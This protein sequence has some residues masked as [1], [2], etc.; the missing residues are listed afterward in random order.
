MEEYL[1]YVGTI[2]GILAAFAIS[3]HAN[4]NATI[5]KAEARA[6]KAR[7]DYVQLLENRIKALE[8]SLQD[9]FNERKII[10]EERDYLRTENF[11]LGRK[12]SELETI[13]RKA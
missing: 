12:V 3:L 5:A 1:P 11:R 13:I 4:R 6:D 7:S 10:T 9:C 8:D 2:L